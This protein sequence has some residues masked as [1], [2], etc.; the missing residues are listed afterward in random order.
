MLRGYQPKLFICLGVDCSQPITDRKSYC[1]IRLI[2]SVQRGEVVEENVFW[3][4]V[5]AVIGK[6]DVDIYCAS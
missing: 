1:L 2:C 5:D 6:Y 3:N 4:V